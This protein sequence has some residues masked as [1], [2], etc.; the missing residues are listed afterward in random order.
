MCDVANSQI[1][2]SEA[3]NAASIENMPFKVLIGKFIYNLNCR[4]HVWNL[5]LPQPPHPKDEERNPWRS[6]QGEIG[7]RSRWPMFSSFQGLQR[8]EYRGYDSA[9]VFWNSDK[10]IWIICCFIIRLGWTELRRMR[11]SLW[12]KVL[13]RWPCCKQRFSLP[14]TFFKFLSFSFHSFNQSK[15]FNKV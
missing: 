6:D 4:K 10:Y 5:C 1:Q 3:P 13:A 9:G 11:V 2:T 8:L 12:S 7:V 15:A 14:I